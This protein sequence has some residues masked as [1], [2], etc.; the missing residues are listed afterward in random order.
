LCCRT[1][2]T[3]DWSILTDSNSTFF[4]L[5]FDFMGGKL[6]LVPQISKFFYRK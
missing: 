6:H 1:K 3:I 5:A 4:S 2:S